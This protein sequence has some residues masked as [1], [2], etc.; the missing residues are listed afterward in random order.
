MATSKASHDLTL[1]GLSGLISTTLL[2]TLG[3]SQLFLL[4]GYENKSVRGEQSG[5]QL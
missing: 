1:G 2:V 5:I 3:F 4:K